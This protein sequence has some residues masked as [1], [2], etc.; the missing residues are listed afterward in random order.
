MFHSPPLFFSPFKITT[1]NRCVKNWTNAFMPLGTPLAYYPNNTTYKFLL[2]I[3]MNYGSLN[4][5]F[6]NDVQQSRESSRPNGSA[7]QRRSQVTT[8][9]TT[10]PIDSLYRKFKHS[11]VD[12]GLFYVQL[13]EKKKKAAHHTGKEYFFTYTASYRD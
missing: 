9:G 7:E 10:V 11:V 6:P 5:W 1:K 3:T 2:Y 12:A 8:T 4:M 13:G